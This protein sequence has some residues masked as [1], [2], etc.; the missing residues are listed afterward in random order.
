[1]N[2]PLNL[3]YIYVFLFLN[4]A[5]SNIKYFKK[6]FIICDVLNSPFWAIM[7]AAVLQ[8]LELIMETGSSAI[9]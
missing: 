2:K 8:G 5:H 3:I 6:I 4:I 1:M 7:K 9:S